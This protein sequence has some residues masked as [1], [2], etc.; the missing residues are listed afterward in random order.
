MKKGILLLTILI[1]I[2]GS[3]K[4]KSVNCDLPCTYDEELI[5]QTGFNNT[6]LEND[7][8]MKDV[9]QII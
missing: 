2:V 3:C 6:S 9:K 5:F 1:I 4:K 8:Y 7:D